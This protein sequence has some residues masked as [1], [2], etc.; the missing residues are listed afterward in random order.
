[1]CI[2]SMAGVEFGAE[3]CCQ[4]H[5]FFILKLLN[6]KIENWESELFWEYRSK[7]MC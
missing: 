1:M 3:L 4:N 2:L 7:I 6:L 5:V